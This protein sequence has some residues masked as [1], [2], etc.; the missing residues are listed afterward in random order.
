MR[1]R[2]FWKHS[3]NVHKLIIR[4]I[5]IKPSLKSYLFE[6]IP[7]WQTLWLFHYNNGL[8]WRS[9]CCQGCAGW[10][11][12]WP[13]GLTSPHSAKVEK[14]NH[15]SWQS[16]ELEKKICCPPPIKILI[17]TRSEYY[18]TWLGEEDVLADRE[19]GAC[20]LMAATLSRSLSCSSTMIRSRSASVSLV[21]IS[22][23]LCASV[24]IETKHVRKWMDQYKSKA[25]VKSGLA[26]RH[27]YKECQI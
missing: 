17:L 13:S 12:I 19:A 2:D 27:F 10:S 6:Y 23:S 11:G 4:G 15:R 1:A 9:P 21:T 24:C 14:I 3:Y 8:P 16:S 7:P 25:Y 26:I 18:L 22:R 20:R 5:Y